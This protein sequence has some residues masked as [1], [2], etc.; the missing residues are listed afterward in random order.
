MKQTPHRVPGKVE[1]VQGAYGKE[2]FAKYL[3][4]NKLGIPMG[5][6][7]FLYAFWL[8]YLGRFCPAHASILEVGCGIGFFATRLHRAFPTVGLDISFNALEF[9]HRYWGIPSLVCGAAESLPFGPDDFDIIFALDVLEHL[10][11]PQ[12]FFRE[13]HRVL[14]QDGLMVVST[15][16]PESVGA[17]RKGRDW[18]AYRDETHISIHQIREWR[19]A[20]TEAGFVIEKDGT[21]FLWDPPYVDWI[22]KAIQ[23]IACISAQWLM[24]WAFGFLAWK[25]GENYVAILRKGPRF[26]AGAPLTLG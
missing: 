4:R 3:Q 17:R 19:L 11:V 26:R 18:F 5:S 9:A 13:A 7:P 20:F 21:D 8:R 10:Q 25:A 1:S 14:T 16:N 22:P 24:T 2:Y 15:P 6:K 12:R 23:R